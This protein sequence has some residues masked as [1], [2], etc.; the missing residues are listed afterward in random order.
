MDELRDRVRGARFFTKIDLKNSYHLVRIKE[1]DEWKTAFR[2]RYGLYEYTVMPFGLSN[3]PATF[4]SMINHIFRDMLDQGLLAFMD[5]LV[6]YTATL[7]EHNKIVL[8][9]LQRLRDN[10]LCIAP[11]KCEWAKDRIEILRYMVSGQGVEMSN[12]KV[13]TLQN[14]KPLETTSS[15]PVFENN[16]KT[17]PPIDSKFSQHHPQLFLLPLLNF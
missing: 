6:I 8:E 13:E 5:D 15:E 16:S 1:G 17:P 2:C 11:D 10:R 12:E 7:Q 3:A 14:I 9:V 4:Q